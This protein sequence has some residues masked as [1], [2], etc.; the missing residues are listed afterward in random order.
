MAS[1]VEISVDG[2]VRT[3]TINRPDKLNALKP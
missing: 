3:L 2:P 1:F